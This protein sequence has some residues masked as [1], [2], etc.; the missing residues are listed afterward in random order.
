MCSDPVLGP[1]V[2][3]GLGGVL[4]EVLKDVS[5]RIAPFSV[6]EAHRMIREIKGY[7]I[8]EGVRGAPPA[9]IDALA[10]ALSNLSVFAAENAERLDS[11]DINPFIVLPEGEGAVAVDA[12]IVPA[13][14]GDT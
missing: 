11:I 12:L 4:V 1:A 6:E 9:D 5:F 2:M 13:G 8:L 7:K 10:E 3:F 14:T